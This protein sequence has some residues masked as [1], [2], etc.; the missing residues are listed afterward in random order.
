MRNI[1]TRAVGSQA[2]VEPEIR[3]LDTYPGDLYLLA[4]DGLTRELS[5]ADIAH[6]FRRFLAR[7]AIRNRAA[8]PDLTILAQTLVDQAN[9][10]GGADN[11]TVL[12]LHVP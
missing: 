3:N 12:L 2:S 7:E 4:S 6:A 11:I 9:D 10:A 8:K 5:D 1:I